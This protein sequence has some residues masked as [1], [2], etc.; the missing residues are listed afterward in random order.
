MKMKQRGTATYRY[1]CMQASEEVRSQVAQC[2]YVYMRAR[3]RKKQQSDQ[4]EAVEI[5][6]GWRSAQIQ[7]TWLSC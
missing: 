5:E 1:M 2:I 3:K 4:V 7:E 6:N